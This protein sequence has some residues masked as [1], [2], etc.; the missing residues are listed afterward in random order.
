VVAIGDDEDIKLAVGD[1]V[2][3][4]KYSGTEFKYNGVDYILFDEGDVL[5]RIK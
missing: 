2:L 5:A 1:I 4:A 3:F